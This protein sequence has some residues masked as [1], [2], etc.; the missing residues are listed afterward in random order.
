MTG[1]SGMWLGVLA[2][3][4]LMLIALAMVDAGGALAQGDPT[5]VDRP[6]EPYEPELKAK[7]KVGPEIGAVRS[8]AD[9]TLAVATD[10]EVLTVT[11]DGVVEVLVDGETLLAQAN[12]EADAAI[13]MF[14]P[15]F[16]AEAT[17]SAIPFALEIVPEG[18]WHIE[19]PGIVSP[20]GSI[21]VLNI[22]DDGSLHIVHTDAAGATM[23]VPLDELGEALPLIIADVET[24]ELSFVSNIVG[25]D[26]P[27]LFEVVDV[28]GTA[29][30][31]GWLEPNGALNLVT[32][33][34][35]EMRWAVME[36]DGTAEVISYNVE[37]IAL[38]GQLN[39][40]AFP[41]GNNVFLIVP[42]EAGQAEVFVF[43]PDDVLVAHEV[44]PMELSPDVAIATIV[45]GA[46]GGPLLLIPNPEAGG[47][48]IVE[49]DPGTAAANTVPIDLDEAYHIADDPEGE[50]LGIFETGPEELAMLVEDEAGGVHLAIVNVDTG[51]TYV[52]E[53]EMAAF[54]AHQAPL[55]ALGGEGMFVAPEGGE[56]VYAFDDEWGQT[57]YVFDNLDG[58]ISGVVIGPDNELF[59][60]DFAGA[61]YV[62]TMLLP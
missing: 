57:A 38:T 28:D 58:G 47:M 60:T 30:V 31:V 14:E 12:I 32:V 61:V 26:R 36:V 53:D 22:N 62:F 2:L 35:G 51:E 49:I 20:D 41:D 5:P 56:T 27:A 25:E 1:K 21:T 46:D 24:L 29:K 42:V 16:V 9:E 43:N 34:A 52:V 19:I 55:W 54:D 23:V 48:Q 15:I 50:P 18:D 33:E 17:A 39:W 11:H 4:A 44:L 37:M 10:I 8:I 6:I 13:T 59:I 3:L 40:M 45:V 7:F